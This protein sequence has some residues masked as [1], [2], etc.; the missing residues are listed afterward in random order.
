MRKCILSIITVL[1][2]VLL[3]G[4]VYAVTV[5]E[6]T[7]KGAFRDKQGLVNSVQFKAGVDDASNVFG[8]VQD[9]IH[10]P[11]HDPDIKFHGDVTCFM[12][13]TKNP[14]IAEFGGPITSSSDPNLVGMFYVVKVI[15]ESPDEI[16]IQFTRTSPTCTEH[17]TT[18][19]LLRGSIHVN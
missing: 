4:T 19:P 11:G 14:L 1:G 3:V 10:L 5:H 12:L 17:V 16:D 2:L 18:E 9:V 6:A 7:G 15:D 8:E 13:D